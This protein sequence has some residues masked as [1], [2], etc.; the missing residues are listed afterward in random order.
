MWTIKVRR[1]TFVIFC[2]LQISFFEIGCNKENEDSANNFVI[3]FISDGDSLIADSLSTL[4]VQVKINPL[5]TSENRAITFSTSLG[6]FSDGST[7]KIVQADTNGLATVLLRS[8]QNGTAIL[9]ATV[10][11]ITIEKILHFSTA[12]PQHLVLNADS[13]SLIH[14]LN[15]TTKIR[16]QLLRYPGSCTNGLLVFFSAADS[17]GYQPGIVNSVSV[18]NI[19]DLATATFTLQDTAFRGNLLIKSWIYT[20]N[21]DSLGTTTV[22]RVY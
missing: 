3:E 10:K 14:Q 18:S 21:N 17:T 19:S 13:A 22:I 9:T 16:T 7:S 5:A 8:T 4:A 15:N 6:T 12:D 1:I 20:Q 2:L 11:N